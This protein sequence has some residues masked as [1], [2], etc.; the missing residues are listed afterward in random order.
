MNE[1]EFVP[2]DDCTN[3]DGCI[4]RCGI[5]D[6]LNE[7]KNVAYQRGETLEQLAGDVE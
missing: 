3:P 7:N 1:Q 4:T 5:Q 6:Y 2:C